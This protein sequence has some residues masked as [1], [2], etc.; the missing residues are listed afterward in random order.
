MY[1]EHW[2]LIDKPFRN[3]PDPHYLYF[4]R[5][6]EEA[7]TRMLYAIT[8]GQGAMLL[9]GDYGCGKTMLS[10]ALLDELDP[11]RFEVAAI[12]Y[13]NLT[14]EDLLRQMLAQCG[15]ETPTHLAKGA[16]VERL[17]AFLERQGAENR[18]TVVL[19]DEA[20]MIADPMT[21]EEV[22]LLLNFQQNRRF[23]LTLLLLGQP[24][25]RDRVRSIPQLLQRL[26][27]RYHVGPLSADEGVRYLRHRLLIAG[28]EQEIFTREAERA[29]VAAGG[30][31]PRRMNSIADLA[32]LVGFGQRAPVVD[33]E[34]VRQ[35]VADLDPEP[36]VTTE[37]PA[38]TP[39]AVVR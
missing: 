32:L 21:L 11:T 13:P 6:H 4:S 12:P 3:T 26:T 16:L 8:E 27:V 10:R 30:G 25:F 28:A 19:I 5:Q 39:P 23:C 14:A 36:A 29:V 9:T 24:E 17:A 37:A 22:R 18:Q 20:Q 31:V 35:V 1:E 38:S 33:E 2:G 7:L 34:I 15:V